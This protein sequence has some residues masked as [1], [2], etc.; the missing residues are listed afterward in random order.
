[1]F[2]RKLALGGSEHSFGIHVA[3]M[4][5]IPITV[6]NRA[7]EIL[8]QLE[9]D[10]TEGIGK[11]S[12]IKVKSPTIQLSMFQVENPELENMKKSLESLDINTLTPI[13]A[14]MKLSELK[15]MIK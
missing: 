2:L 14:L 1:L 7:G 10:R 3:K 13:E 12:N 9:Q 5:G 6:T 4:A 8:K 11:N 15:Q